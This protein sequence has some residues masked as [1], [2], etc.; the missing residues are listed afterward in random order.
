MATR[1]KIMLIFGT[2][3]EAT[4]M[5]PVVQ[6]LKKHPEW[7]ETKV[8]VTGQHREQLD[9]VLAHFGIRPDVDLN[10]MKENQSLAYI[11]SAAVTGLDKVISEEKPDLILIHGDT[12]TAMCGGMVSFFHKIPIGHIEAGLRSQNKYSPWPEEMNRK[13]IDV[14][15]DFLFAPT[16][17]SK[18]NLLKEGYNTEDIHVTGQ[19]AVD[20][21]IMTNR[22]D[23]VF[24][25]ARLNHIFKQKSKIIT[26]TAHRKENYGEPMFQMFRAIRR[27]ADENPDV[28]V[29]YPIHLSP[30]VRESAFQMLSGHDRIHLLDPINY[31]DMIN[32]LSRSFLVLSD[33]GGLQEETPVFKK[34]L[35][36]MRDI[37]ERPE[38]VTAKA[39]YLAG[40][41]EDSIYAVT[42][43]L[44]TDMTFYNSMSNVV[45]P[46]GDGQASRRIVQIIAH[47]FG[48]AS[49]LPK[50]FIG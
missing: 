2:R 29:I 13:V 15:T 22:T 36:L 30:I 28:S 32:L 4:K 46:F 16:S 18:D 14:V 37:T 25:E 21:A 44:L 17:I 26:M 8:I 43:R 24:S 9:Q 7:F 3:P 48:F 40:T 23:Y 41:E 42:A 27:I 45:N 47:H 10:L 6:E 12:Q 1:K 33:S 39:V 35:V 11:T 38:A 31:P 49:E 19:T 50:E 34:P 5:G 20:A